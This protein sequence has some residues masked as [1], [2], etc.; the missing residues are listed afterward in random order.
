MPVISPDGRTVAFTAQDAAG[1]RLIW[2]RPVDSLTAQPLAGTDGAAYPFWS[3]DSRF[4]GYAITGKLIKIAATGGPTT[5][6]CTLNPGIIS[7]GGSWSRDNVIVFNN[8]PAPIYKV[9]S[10][11]GDAIAMGKL[12]DGESGRQFPSFLPDG[13]HFLYSASGTEAKGGVFV[14]SIDG[15]DAKRVVSSPNGA[16]YDNRSGHLLFIRQG[17]LVAQPF[18]LKTL[19]LTGEAFPIA[20]R[21]ESTAVS[22]VVAFSVSNTGVLAYGVGEAAGAGFQPT[23]VDR[24]GKVTGTVG[25]E[26]QYRGIGLSPDGSRFAAHRHDGDGGDIWVTDV[27]QNRT[28]RFTFDAAQENS[29]PVWSPRGDRIAYASTRDGKAGI[30][31]RSADGTGVEGRLFESPTSRLAMPF[32]WTAD[33]SSIVFLMPSA[34]TGNDLWTVPVSGDRKAVPVLNS[35]FAESQG[36]YSPDGRWL[37]YTSNETGVAEVYVQPASGRGGKQVVSTGGGAAPRW[38]GDSLELFY[39][40]LGKMWA[41]S[42]TAGGTGFKSASPKALFDYI[43]STANLGHAAH[44]SYAVSKDGLRFLIPTRKAAGEG[45]TTQ[46]PIVVVTN[47]LDSVKK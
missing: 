24:N 33:G 1:K 23:W 4:L 6:L 13:R 17:T 20:E 36:Q 2:V 40:G 19:A 8:G 39:V 47:W 41:A 29:S 18:D 37:A 14:A 30:S 5:T 46:A 34:P 27:G 32:S 12:E 9:S 16:V 11:G 7:R 42:V 22:G 10:A 45:A 43:G 15:G 31:V 35:P 44:F 38:R 3:P 25:P 21:V 26:A 28:T